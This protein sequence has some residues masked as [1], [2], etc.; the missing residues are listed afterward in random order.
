MTSDG[1]L[2]ELNT[3][4]RETALRL[5][6]PLVERSAWVAEQV[7]DARPFASDQD[8]AQRL[9]DTILEAGF[10]KRVALFRAHPEL[11][12]R[13]AVAGTM[14]DASTGEQDRLGLTSLGPDAAARLAGMNATYA[15]RFGHPFILALH[16]VPDLDTVFD[17][18]ERRLAASPVE[19]HVSTLAE[20]ASVI[21]ARAARAFATS[22]E[23]V[24]TSHPVE[25][26][27]G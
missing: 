15:A 6:E 19:E 18:F 5:L 26:A 2:D 9:V 10:E 20:I 22:S 8:V 7:V 16:R 13:E 25:A 23:P 17:I 27:D 11:A 1:R 24:S 14:T 12:G 4:P 3:A 21:C